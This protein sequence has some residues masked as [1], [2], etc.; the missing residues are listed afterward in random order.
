MANSL[1]LNGGAWNFHSSSILEERLKAVCE[2][3]GAKSL[4]CLRLAALTPDPE[5]DSA[6]E[7]LYQRACSKYSAKAV[8]RKLW[9]LHR[10]GYVDYGISVR[11][12]RLTEKGHQALAPAVM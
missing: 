3:D 12:A 2:T 6:W 7:V 11:T 5:M 1:S 4:D 10:R 8:Y 9:E